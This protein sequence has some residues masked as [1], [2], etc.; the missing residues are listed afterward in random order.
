M[1]PPG[2]G[3]NPS[4]TWLEGGGELAS[5]LFPVGLSRGVGRDA[6]GLIG[7]PGAG[8]P[9]GELVAAG[10]IELGANPRI[11]RLARSSLGQAE[12]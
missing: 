5:Y 11:E 9:A 8:Q 4:Q 6:D 1:R 3:L 7:A 2:G 12:T 10:E